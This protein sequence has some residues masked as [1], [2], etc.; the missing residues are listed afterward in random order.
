M[1]TRYIVQLIM[2]A[3]GT[4]DEYTPAKLTEMEA[5]IAAYAGVAASLVTIT[6]ASGSVVLTAKILVDSFALQTP[7][8]SNV[9]AALGTPSAPTNIFA[10]VSGGGVTIN[11]FSV[12]NTIEKLLIAPPAVPLLIAPP[13][14]S[15]INIDGD[16]GNGGIVGVVIGAS[17]ALLVAIGAYTYYLKNNNKVGS[18]PA[19]HQHVTSTVSTPQ[20][21]N[22]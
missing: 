20:S 17:G 10:S 2:I 13:P 7:V 5:V 19:A 22:P 14:M 21:D 3:E 12:A 16:G 4:V 18:Y 11:A 6:V 15:P 1:D 8:N 9:A